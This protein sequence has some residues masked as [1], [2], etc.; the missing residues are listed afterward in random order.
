[1]FV[2]LPGLA[3]VAIFLAAALG[4]AIVLMRYIYRKDGVEHEPKD[5][6][7]RLV[8]RGVVAALLSIVLEVI[9]QKILDM[10]QISPSSPVYVIL[11]AFF[12]VAAVEEGTK[13]LLMHGKV[14]RHPSFNY[15]FDAIVYSAFVSL[16][17]AAF[18]NLQY[19][20]SYGLSVAFPRAVLA[21]PGHLGFSV[22]FGYFYGRA[23]MAS[24]AG[25]HRACVQ[26]IVLGYVSAVC[27]HGFYDA[28][29]MMGTGLSTLVFLAFV[30]IMYIV[31]L[32]LIRNESATDAPIE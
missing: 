31:I 4:P 5:L 15:R 3:I 19:V 28:C 20:R 30:V 6:L 7:W 32:R 22:L 2:A 23:K 10:T 9:A 1:M 12:V 25:D 21:V 16:G 13:Y 17:F 27:M 24:K 18:E 26:N 8:L 29:A 11:L 14:W